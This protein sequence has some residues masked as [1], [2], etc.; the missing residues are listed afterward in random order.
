MGRLLG[1]LQR[2][3]VGYLALFVAL[4]G[5]SFAAAALINGSQ[6]KPHTIPKNRLT[7]SAIASLK[8]SRGPRGPQ[9]DSGPQGSTGLQGAQ[10]AQGA[11]GPQGPPGVQGPPGPVSAYEVL[12]PALPTD[13][14]ATSANSPT[15]VTQVDV[16]A[17]SY[18]VSMG[19]VVT[20]TG[21]DGSVTCDVDHLIN[22][23][24]DIVGAGTAAVGTTAGTSRLTTLVGQGGVTLTAAGT[25]RLSCWQSSAGATMPQ[26]RFA[27]VIAIKVGSLTQTTG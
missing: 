5:T 10:G 18:A 12:H 2:H 4:G 15:V 6:I 11:A 17:G 22:G 20:A 8:G 23:T 26:A 13:I 24:V 1:H 14:T 25:L 19:V 16:P 3:L 7:K 21:G 27:D 9:G